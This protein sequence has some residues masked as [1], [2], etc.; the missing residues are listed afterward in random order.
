M[1]RTL[2][3]L[4]ITAAAAVAVPSM[5]S[6]SEARTALPSSGRTLAIGDLGCFAMSYG[7][8]ING[9]SSMKILEVPLTHDN[10]FNNWLFPRVTAFGSAPAG[11][12]GCTVTA[13]HKAGYYWSN[14]VGYE[15]VPVF[16][17]YQDLSL[18]VYATGD[19]GLYVTCQV[20]PNASVNLIQW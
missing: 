5:Q 6:S 4:S 13:M 20:Y 3:L 8:M 19:T 16:G 15:F 11:N 1:N 14:P 18:E 2:Q 12:V 9:C 7:A 17:S 10:T